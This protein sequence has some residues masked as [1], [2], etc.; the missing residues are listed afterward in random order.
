MKTRWSA[1]AVDDEEGEDGLEDEGEGEHPVVER[2]LEDRETFR[3]SLDCATPLDQHHA[4][5]D[6]I[7]LYLLGEMFT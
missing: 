6:K 1:W 5:E 4:E 7:D 3:S 2:T